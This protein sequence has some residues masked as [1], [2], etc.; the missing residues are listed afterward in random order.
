MQKD[1]MSLLLNWFGFWLSSYTGWRA[2]VLV[3]NME[4]YLPS[5]VIMPRNG[6][7]WHDS[8][9]SQNLLPG[10]GVVFHL[11]VEGKWWWPAAVETGFPMTNFNTSAEALLICV[12]IRPTSQGL[13][14][15][16]E[17]STLNET[18][19]GILHFIK[20]FTKYKAQTQLSTSTTKQN[21]ISG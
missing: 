19:F 13:K 1:S 12:Y 20:V 17:V 10:Q 9:V 15:K 21:Q 2:V 4:L 6:R 16:T 7:K 5:T 14:K 11:V 18:I 8:R 3:S